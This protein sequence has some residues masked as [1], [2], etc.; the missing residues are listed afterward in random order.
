MHHP[1]SLY[2]LKLSHSYFQWPTYWQSITSMIGLSKTIKPYCG[3]FLS[4]ETRYSQIN[5]PAGQIITAVR[6]P[7]PQWERSPLFLSAKF[8]TGAQSSLRNSELQKNINHDSVL[9]HYIAFYFLHLRLFPV[10]DLNLWQS[11]LRKSSKASKDAAHVLIFT[12]DGSQMSWKLKS[13]AS[14]DDSKQCAWATRVLHLISTPSPKND[15]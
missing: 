2:N 10:A 12:V 9:S 1:V 3:P 8:T 7:S 5:G 15:I 4:H 6:T 11:L 13:D 14:N